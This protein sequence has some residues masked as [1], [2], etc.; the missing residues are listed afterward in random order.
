[1]SS[2]PLAHNA[3]EFLFPPGRVTMLGESDGNRLRRVYTDGRTHPAEPELTFHGHS[4]GHWE[5]HT[6]VINTIGVLPQSYL[7]VSEGVGIP[8]NGDMRIKERIYS[9]APDVMHV[10]LE[11]SAPKILTKP[12]TTTRIYYRQRARKYDIVE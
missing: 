6:L 11:I 9:A 4:I 8:N 3:L 2:M 12:W 7:A 1:P 10:D 5:E